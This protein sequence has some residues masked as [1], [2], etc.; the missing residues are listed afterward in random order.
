MH[1]VMRA[2][3]RPCMRSSMWPV[4]LPPQVVKLLFYGLN[5]VTPVEPNPDFVEQLRAVGACSD[6]FFRK[7]SGFFM[8][9]CEY[10]GSR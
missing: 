5:G 10:C 2:P 1:V 9:S 3:M 6:S 4:H 8:F 7:F